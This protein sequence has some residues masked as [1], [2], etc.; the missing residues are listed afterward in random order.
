VTLLVNEAQATQVQIPQT[1]SARFS[2]DETFDIRQDSGAPVIEDY[3]EQM[4][5]RFIGTLTK[6]AA[7]L[8]P[9]KLSA[10][11]QSRCMLNSLAP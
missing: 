9:S 11:E 10:D 7:V 1:V 3:V 6:F 8:E 5:F 4:P 2:L